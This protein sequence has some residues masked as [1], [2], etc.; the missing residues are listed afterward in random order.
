VFLRRMRIEER[1]LSNALGRP[2]IDYK[3]RTKRLVPF[4]Y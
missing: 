1:A 2:Y 4:V 3:A